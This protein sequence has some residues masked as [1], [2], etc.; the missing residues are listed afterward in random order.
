MVD[1]TVEGYV[2]RRDRRG[3]RGGVGPRGAVEQ[4]Q[5]SSTRS[6]SPSRR[7]TERSGGGLSAEF[8]AD[9]LV[10]DA[11]EA[12]DRR[13]ES[14]GVGPDTVDGRRGV[15]GEP[16]MRE[17][18]RRVLLSVLD[19]KWREHLYE[20]DYLQEGIGL[21]GYGQRDPLVEYQR[22]AFDMF[23][24]MMEA[25]KE[26]SVGL[27]VLRRRGHPDRRRRVGASGRARATARR[28]RCGSC[29]NRSRRARTQ[30]P[31]QGGGR[32][33]SGVRAAGPA[34]QSAVLR[35]HRGRGRCCGASRGGQP[36]VRACRLVRRR[37]AQ[38]SLPLRVRAEVQALS[39]R[40]AEPLIAARSLSVSRPA[41]RCIASARRRPR[42]ASREPVVAVRCRRRR[43]PP[44]HRPSAR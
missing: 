19:R 32:P 30:R 17:L 24:A 34:G 13:E 25:I 39:R 31:R 29:G 42:V 11:Q 40:A 14:L 16:V 41:T 8:L 21:R 27:P 43:R 7:S 22:E 23:G 9:E 38:C 3:L 12:Y 37:V 33:R 36:A 6:A 10:A 35:A 2:E 18:E 4:P 44:P 5:G 26:E 20:M 1:D 15:P 28:K